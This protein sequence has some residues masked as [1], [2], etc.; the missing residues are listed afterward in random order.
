MNITNMMPRSVAVNPLA[1]IDR[2]IAELELGAQLYESVTASY[3]AV[4]AAL[5]KI[6][7]ELQVSIFPQGS[8]RLGTTILHL[9][10]ER[11]DLDMV[12]SLAI[13]GKIYTPEQ[14][15][16]LVW[17]A[18]GQ[19]DTYRQ[20]RQK[21]NRCI[22]IEYAPE[23]KYYLDI[24]PA[25]PDWVISGSLYVPD[26]E[27]KVWC[28]SH[29]VAYCDKWFKTACKELPTFRPIMLRNMSAAVVMAN[30]KTSVEPMP[31]FGAFEKTPL[32]RIVQ[33]LKHDR[34]DHFQNDTAHRPSSILLTTITTKSYL[35]S[36]NRPVDDLLEFVI[37]V[38]KGLPEFIYMTGIES[39]QKYHV[40]NPVNPNE[41]FAECWTGEHYVRFLMWQKR[42]VARL[43]KL[44]QAKGRG[45]D[46]MMNRLSETFGNNQ[47]IKAARA[48]GV[49]ANALHDAGELRV[50]AGVVGT[51]GASIPATI[52]FGSDN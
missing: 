49:D 2:I 52:N 17:D 41:N 20:M 36:V 43:E 33:M 45:T 25:V 34:N 31:E 12:C 26:R 19:H 3:E 6:H 29:P 16:E 5:A 40:L 7:P 38:V 47:V 44:Q 23:C 4:A 11:F 46:V 51:A 37:N 35:E 30:A 15:F 39:V 50:S 1:L 14:V 32:Q 48:L 21:K 10:G 8:M 42:A 24:V 13:S 27:R 18:L 22:R 28:P 9:F